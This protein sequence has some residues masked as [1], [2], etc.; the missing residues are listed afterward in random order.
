MFVTHSAVTLGAAAP[1]QRAYA[2]QHAQTP[3]Y[4]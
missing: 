1:V 2:Q 3:A 4:F